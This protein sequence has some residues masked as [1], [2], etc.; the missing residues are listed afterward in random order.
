MAAFHARDR[1]PDRQA[2]REANQV[3]D[4]A[5]PSETTVIAYRA[6]TQRRG[7]RRSGSTCAACPHIRARHPRTI[8]D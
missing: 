5:T 4:G 2:M 7:R 6:A 1:T 3:P 8:R